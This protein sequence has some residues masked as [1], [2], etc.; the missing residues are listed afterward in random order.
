MA[1][2]SSRIA[3]VTGGMGGIGTAICERLCS[4][5]YRVVAG[6]GPTSTRKERWLGDMRA[7]GFEVHASV[8]NVSDWDSTVAAF[9][10]VRAE[11]GLP[12]IGVHGTASHDARKN[13][14]RIV[15]R[16]IN[17]R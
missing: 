3:Y 10:K 7:K 9:E 2:K 8:G 6:C 15:T 1:S 5:G 12:G 14:K 17:K 4:E 11:I 13:N 16:L